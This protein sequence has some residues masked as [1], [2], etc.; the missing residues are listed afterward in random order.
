VNIVSD[1]VALKAGKSQVAASAAPAW[2]A[3]VKALVPQGSA[4]R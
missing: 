2:P 4:E 3:A 1:S